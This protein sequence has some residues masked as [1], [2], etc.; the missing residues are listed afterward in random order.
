MARRLSDRERAWRPFADLLD[1][2]A[3]RARERIQRLD[4]S[5]AERA[6]VLD[7]LARRGR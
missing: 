7:L 6:L 4:L 2:D 5:P 1:L 3:G